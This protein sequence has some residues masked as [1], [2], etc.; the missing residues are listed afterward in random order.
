RVA[1]DRPYLL[2]E[3]QHGV[4]EELARTLGDLLIRRT[5][6]A[7]ETVDHGR[8][9]ARNVAGRVGTWLGWSEDETAGALAAYDAEVARLFTVEA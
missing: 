3:L 6:V 8:T 2:A 9:A 5:P 1:P 4:T 7:F